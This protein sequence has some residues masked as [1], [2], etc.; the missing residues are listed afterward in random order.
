MEPHGHPGP[1]PRLRGREEALKALGDAFA[2]VIAGHL[3][4]VVVEGE[5][6]IGKTRLL[7]DYEGHDAARGVAR[8]EATLREL[9]IRRGRRGLRRRPR[10]D[11]GW[12]R[13]RM[14]PM[15]PPARPPQQC[16]RDALDRLERDV[17]AWVATADPTPTGTSASTPNGS[18]RGAKPTSSPT[19]T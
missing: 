3:T 15:T 19:A 10:V 8:V 6:G 5:A 18:R 16:K 2:R 13:G 1:S 11:S 7:A 4:I 17:D 12:G 14:P 9:G